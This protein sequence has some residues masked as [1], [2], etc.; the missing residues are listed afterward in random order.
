MSDST[1]ALRRAFA[2]GKSTVLFGDGSYYINGTV[3][4][5]ASVNYVDFNFCQLVSGPR[6]IGGEVACAF[7]IAEASDETLFLENL[8]TQEQFYGHMRLLGQTSV[9]EVVL[10][11]LQTTMACLY[12]NTVGGSR[13]WL[14]NIFLTTGT[15]C[16]DRVLR[17]EGMRPVYS[18]NIPIELHGQT[19]IG[20]GVNLERA[21]VAMLCDAS[22][23]WLDG[24][25]TEGPGTALKLT[26]GSRATVRVFNAGIGDRDGVRPL[27]D[28]DESVPDLFGVRAVG[29]N[30][31][32]EYNILVRQRWQGRE[33]RYVQDDAKHRPSAHAL[34]VERYLGECPENFG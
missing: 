19:L 20:R 13:I 33:Y 10:S 9:R 28:A 34:L 2:S 22:E 11:D 6:L 29:Y 5:P 17:R 15:Y 4:I 30:E 18:R 32:T 26:G 8:Y 24:F 21:E 27:F 7:E 3:K 12:F 16:D 14:D 23:V 31:S 25:R 1:E